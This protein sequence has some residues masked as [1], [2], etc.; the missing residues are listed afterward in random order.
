MGIVSENLAVRAILQRMIEDGRLA[1]VE[2]IQA[3]IIAWER[4]ATVLGPDLARVV[5]V[6]Y[7][8]GPLTL[9]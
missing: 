6:V 1:E 8:L 2:K 4:D 3:Q 7:G 9:H 5:L